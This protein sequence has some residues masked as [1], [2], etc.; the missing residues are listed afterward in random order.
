MGGI[1][2]RGVA[3]RRCARFEPSSSRNRFSSISAARLASSAGTLLCGG[4]LFSAGFGVA[5]GVSFAGSGM[6][7]VGEIGGSSGR[8]AVGGGDGGSVGTLGS[9]WGFSCSGAGVAGGRVATGIAGDGEAVGGSAITLSR[10]VWRSRFLR[11]SCSESSRACARSRSSS[12]GFAGSGVGRSD[13][14]GNRT[15]S[16]AHRCPWS[17]VL[18]PW[19]S[20]RRRVPA[21]AVDTPR[22]TVHHRQAGGSCT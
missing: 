2:G 9:D 20:P 11:P 10:A 1:A 7:G 8:I 18:W 4:G 19:R 16:G 12:T 17:K 14:T 3:A 5:I 13:A 22:N 15:E 6:G 21:A